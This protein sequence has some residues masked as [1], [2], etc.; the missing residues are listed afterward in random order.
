MPRPSSGPRQLDSTGIWYACKTVKGKRH[1]VSLGTKLRSEAMR[2]W[3][4]AQAELEASLSPLKLPWDTTM[5]TLQPNA[6]GQW[7]AVDEQAW[8]LLHEDQLLDTDDPSCISWKEAEDIAAKRYKRRRGKAPSRSWH[9]AIKYALKHMKMTHPLQV[10][11]AS[12]R[13]MVSDM[14]DQGLAAT[15]I[16][17]RTSALSGLIEALIRT[18]HTADD[19]INPFSRIDTSAISTNHFYK[20]VESDYKSIGAF[21]GG[22]TPFAFYLTVLVYTGARISE[23]INGDYSEPGWLVIHNGKNRSSVRRVPLPVVSEGC[24]QQKVARRKPGDTNPLERCKLEDMSIDTFRTHFNNHRS[25]PLLTPHS[26]RHGWATAARTAGAD[27][28]TSERLLGHAI[29]KMAQV[30]GSFNDEVL[31]REAA[32]VWDVIDGWVELPR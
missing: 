9:T 15:T 2:R 16:Q 21:L 28:I 17:Q 25:H 19:Y 27:H 11:P 23:V 3:P 8:S 24:K 10:T 22:D 18:G 1:A 32:K 30:Y 13:Q 20:A 26:F 29:P 4:A 14:E 6:Q 7:V 5:R 12:V 31:Q